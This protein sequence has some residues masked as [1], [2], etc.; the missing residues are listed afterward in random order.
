V[1]RKLEPEGIGPLELAFRQTVARLGAE[2]LFDPGR[3]R[4]LPRF[5]RRIV[6]VT[7]PSGAAIRDLLQVIGRR[8]TATEIL[9]AP[10]RVQGAGAAPEVA[11]A[12]AL[13]GRVAGADLIIVARG[14]GSLEDLW[15]FN[16]EVVARAIFASP[17]PV[18]SAIGHEIDLTIADL[19]ADRRALTPSEAG[20]LCVPDLGEVRGVLDS[21]RARLARSASVRLSQTRVV[22]DTLADRA[23]RAMRLHLDQRRQALAHRAAQLEALSPLAVLSRGYSVTLRADGVS[24]ARSAAELAPGDRIQTRLAVGMVVSKV[25]TSDPTAQ[26]PSPLRVR[27]PRARKPPSP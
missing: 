18:I 11:A 1:V 26:W 20:E 6:L 21:I 13:A 27:K 14:G 25:E 4:P 12:I 8:W 2:G 7:S 5:P 24:V 17:L 10:T 22:L 19:V 3:K 15:A 9:I 23:R 16:E